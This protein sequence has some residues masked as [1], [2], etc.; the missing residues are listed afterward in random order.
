MTTA[1]STRVRIATSSSVYESRDA[2]MTQLVV[3][4]ICQRHFIISG[5]I[6]GIPTLKVTALQRL[7]W[8]AGQIPQR[9]REAGES[10]LGRRPGRHVDSR[11]ACGDGRQLAGGRSCTITP[12]ASDR[13]QAKGTDSPDHE[14]KPYLQGAPLQRRANGGEGYGP[15]Q[16]ARQVREALVL[17]PGSGVELAAGTKAS[18]VG[19]GKR[20]RQG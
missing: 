14:A 19:K 15:E 5:I 2:S 6:R 3:K 11:F 1:D 17:G 4:L 13:A 10:D 9:R 7:T 8:D 12:A 18:G 16:C 20:F